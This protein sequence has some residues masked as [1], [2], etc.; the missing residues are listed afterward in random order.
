MENKLLPGCQTAIFAY[1]KHKSIVQ[2]NKR[3]LLSIG[4]NAMF[5]FQYKNVTNIHYI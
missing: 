1:Y 4:K 3:F 5:N 2:I